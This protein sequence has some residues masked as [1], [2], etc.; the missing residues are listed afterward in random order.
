MAVL[1]QFFI[2]VVEFFPKLLKQVQLMIYKDE[3]MGA[4]EEKEEGKK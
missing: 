2:A 4:E 3:R 1:L